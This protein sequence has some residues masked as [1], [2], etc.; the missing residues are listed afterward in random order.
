MQIS[1]LFNFEIELIAACVVELAFAHRPPWHRR[2]PKPS[3]ARKRNRKRKRRV[4]SSS[5]SSSGSDSDSSSSEA[6]PSVPAA[7]KPKAVVVA[8]GEDSDSDS[9]E[10]SSSSDSSSDSDEDIGAARPSEQVSNVVRSAQDTRMR[11]PSPEPPLPGSIP[12]PSFIPTTG[13]A[14]E[15]SMKEQELK[16]KFR[17][18]WMTTIVDAFAD[19][20][21]ELRKVRKCSLRSHGR[22]FLMVLSEPL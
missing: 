1:D 8:E 4:A 12:I 20:L 6:G 5:E 3:A 16:D 14:G 2:P 9:S 13:N 21:N 19:D 7:A 15:D 22:T 17:K 10:S 18:F 11:S